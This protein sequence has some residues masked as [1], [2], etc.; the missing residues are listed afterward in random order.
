MANAICLKVDNGMMATR[1][2]VAARIRPATVMAWDASR[3]SDD[4]SLRHRAPL[5]LIPDGA[6]REHVV[7]RAERDEQDGRRERGVERQPLCTEGSAGTPVWSGPGPRSRS[8]T[9]REKSERRD[10]GAQVQTEDDQLDQ[11]GHDQRD[12]QAVRVS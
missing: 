3:D 10:Q 11:Q 1:A 6:D 7:V 2:K 8:D 9:A 5:G 4:Q 12:L